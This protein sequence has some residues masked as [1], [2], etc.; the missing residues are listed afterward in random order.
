MTRAANRLPGWQGATLAGV[1]IVTLA[2]GVAW[3]ALHYASGAA[4]DLPHPAEAWLMR[5]HGLA[6]FGALFVLGALAAAH[7]PQGWRV[8]SRL[9][10]TRQ[11]T[12]GLLLCGLAAAVALT[13]YALYYFA[14]EPVRPALGWTHAALG[15]AITALALQHRRHRT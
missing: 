6:A 2:T 5:L 3:L 15:F 13:G 12:S 1:G 11:R 4:A 7:V 9:G 10:W 14:P 8:V